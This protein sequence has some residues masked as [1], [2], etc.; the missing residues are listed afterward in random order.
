MFGRN[1]ELGALRAAVEAG[2]SVLVLGAAG[3]GKTTL[4]DTAIAS[5]DDRPDRPRCHVF[6]GAG[7]ELLQEEPYLALTVAMGRDRWSRGAARRPGD[8]SHPPVTAPARQWG[9]RCRHLPQRTRQLE[10][11]GIVHQGGTSAEIASALGI[12]RSTVESH[13]RMAMHTLGT[14]S[15][16]EAARRAALIDQG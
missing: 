5:L 8:C 1:E 3:I 7:I 13:I 15:R 4:L 6:R 2:R 14:S 12:A 9:A 11:L 16:R 10:I